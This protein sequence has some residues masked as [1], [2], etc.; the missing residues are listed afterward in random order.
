MVKYD[1][2][3]GAEIR[4]SDLRLAVRKGHLDIVKYLLDHGA[5]IHAGDDC[6]LIEAVREGHLD[7]VKYLLDHWC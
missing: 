5:D 7:I 4:D 3:Q 1:I 6:A 2:D